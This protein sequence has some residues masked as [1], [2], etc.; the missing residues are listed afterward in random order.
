MIHIKKKNKLSIL[1]QFNLTN[2]MTFFKKDMILHD[3]VSL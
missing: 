3:T 2:F 1:S